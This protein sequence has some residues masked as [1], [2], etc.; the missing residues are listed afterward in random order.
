MQDIAIPHRSL[1][2]FSF[3]LLLHDR[4]KYYGLEKYINK[5]EQ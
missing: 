3:L 4:D 1:P 5:P 2:T